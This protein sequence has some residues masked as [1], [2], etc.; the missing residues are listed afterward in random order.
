MTRI[1][2]EPEQRPRA[3][4]A[5]EP[6][7][8]TPP[9]RPTGAGPTERVA[10]L[11]RQVGNAA[12]ARSLG[13]GGET[14]PQ[15]APSATAPEARGPEARIAPERPSG[16]AAEARPELGPSAEVAPAGAAAEAA[17]GVELLMPEP[18]QDLSGAERERLGQAQQNATR[19]AEAEGELPSAESTVGEARQA[20]E[21]PAEET[22][23]RAE[24]QLA[25][26][27]GE[28]PEPSPEIEELCQ[29]IYQAIRSRRPPDEESL[30]RADPEEM[31]RA[32][33]S[34]LDSSVQGDVER[35]QGSYDELNTP[36]EGTPA[37]QPQ[38][39][40]TPPE[41]V[42][43][44]EVGAAAATPDAVP[45]E[46]VSLDAD[47]A[48]SQT[49]MDEAGMTSEPAQLVQSGPVAEARQ[50][51]GELEETAQ[52]DP[53]E[54]LAEQQAALDQAGA[55]MAELQQAALEA[56][57]ASRRAAIH[58]R[59]TG[60]EGMVGSEQQT[61]ARISAQAQA[62]FDDAQRQVNALLEPLVRT[63]MNRWE[64]GV[65][66]LSTRFEQRLR[67]VEAWIEERHAGIGGAIVAAVE[68]V[69]G[70]PDW[71]TEEYDAAEQDFGDGVCNLVREISTEVNGIVA[72][73]EAIIDDARTRIDALFTNLPEQLQAWAEGERARFGEQ[74]DGLSQQVTDTR[75]DFT[76]DLADRAAQ[77]VQESRER[78]HALRQAAGGLVGRV[79]DAV[80]RFLEDPWKFIIE[81]LLELVG[82]P[83]ASFWALVDRIQQVIQDIANDPLGFAENLLSAIGQGFSQFFDNIGQHLLQGLLDWLF[84]GLGSVG[85]EIPTDLSLRSIITFFLQ[86]M[87]ITWERIRR[88][89]ARHIG[90]E[91]VALIEKAYELV[92]T[93]I[94]MG[95]QGIFEMIKDRLNPQEILNQVLEAA[96]QF[97]IEALI[98]QVAV[99]IIMLFNP[100][101]AIAQAIEA[102]YRVL[103][104]IFEN[105]ARIFRLVETVVNGIA[106]I[107]A[108]NIGGMANAVEQALAGLITPVI[109][110]L[111]G[112][113]GLGDLPERIADVIR[114]F[115][116]TVERILD[117]V[118][119]WLAERARQI[120]A[121]LGLG[122]Q[123]QEEQG[124]EDDGDTITEQL[125]MGSEAH[126]LRIKTGTREVTLDSDEAAME[127]K[128]NA[129][130]TK[131]RE[132]EEN[133][134]AEEATQAIRRMQSLLQQI[135][136]ALQAGREVDRARLRDFSRQT[137]QALES[138]GQK[139][140]VNKIVDGL[141]E[142]GPVVVDEHP[143]GRVAQPDGSTRESH[144]VPPKE[145]AQSLAREMSETAS[146]LSDTGDSAA[147]AAATILQSRAQ[148]IQGNTEGTRLSAISLHRVTHQNAGGVAVHAAAMRED[149][150][151]A[152]AAIDASTQEET[153]RIMNRASD[154]MAVNP[155]GATFDQWVRDVYAELDRE[156]ASDADRAHAE[157]VVREARTEMDEEEQKAE[158]DGQRTVQERL[159]R[160]IDRAF[161]SSLTQAKAAVIEAL[162]HSV[163][164]GPQDEAMEQARKIDAE[165]ERT[166]KA[167]G[168]LTD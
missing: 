164:D 112:Y 43:T 83:P 167:K 101:G 56:L 73:C 67:R 85:V 102:I 113:L 59:R 28:R 74:L 128:L 41:S 68:Y 51:Q 149:I 163:I 106:D 37:R 138:Y 125:R 61:R 140:N 82:I 90:E 62:I 107:L 118:I 16:E 36:A 136:S 47:V 14:A 116:E 130:L 40:E 108:G 22:T 131:L 94:E 78:I 135:F 150:E 21:E 9:P 114:G 31:A 120:L 4:R 52:R 34:E 3:A 103:K 77:S 84:S 12:V 109:D 57:N 151:A 119:G 23:A 96:V 15:A 123:E 152:I 58:G 76:R 122:R 13:G 117:R 72:T 55:D 11:Q 162:R 91:N 5:P 64:R 134:Q 111:A 159:A 42:E 153:I 98:K 44:P 26:A 27:L 148:S 126:T 66:V 45:A 49:R 46:D 121:R 165:A 63:A 71:V 168:I 137:K 110:F 87:G 89:L 104:W 20:V 48:A 70:L 24:Q 33:G 50:A 154:T 10:E 6:S 160:M 80:N 79:M 69:I 86:L 25:A 1:A 156:D 147:A 158:A 19:A 93:L 124:E 54:V 129:G 95:P 88:I 32:A 29:R 146:E 105:A 143:A 65:Q 53:A 127:Q 157:S 132:Y 30:V 97:L 7:R 60:Q 81:G 100:V 166:W 161:R 92:A 144:H 99:R 141:P 35:V 17:P 139:F 2:A 39:I 145:L 142:F 18:S 115:Q 155:S 8:E 38:S 133:A 75:D